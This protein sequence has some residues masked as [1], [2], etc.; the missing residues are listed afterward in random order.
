[1]DIETLEKNSLV[2][3]KSDD[4]REL[5]EKA[6]AKQPVPVPTPTNQTPI[7]Q[8]QALAEWKT[9]RQRLARLRRLGLLEALELNGRIFYRPSAYADAMQSLNRH[10]K[11]LV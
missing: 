3:L 7:P 6:A 8:S 4:L 5:L 9:T 2:I 1:M 10:K 11:P